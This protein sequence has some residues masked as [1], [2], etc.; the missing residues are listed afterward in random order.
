[1]LQ[2]LR[3]IPGRPI[4][5]P[6]LTNLS[7]GAD[8]LGR[9]AETFFEIIESRCGD[10]DRGDVVRLMELEIVGKEK[11]QWK[12]MDIIWNESNLLERWNSVCGKINIVEKEE[13][14][15]CTRKC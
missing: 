8:A 9:C 7:T 4:I 2:L 10:D 6:K 12:A 13:Y 15:W 3:I 14:A 5:L 11:A 1:M